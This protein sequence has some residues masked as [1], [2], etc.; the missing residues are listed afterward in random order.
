M[1]FIRRQKYKICTFLESWL[2]RKVVETENR[3]LTLIESTML[4]FGYYVWIITNP[5][6]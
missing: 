5:Y 2:E 4:I 3:E 1:G 6:K